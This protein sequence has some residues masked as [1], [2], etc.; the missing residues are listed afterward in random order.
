MR[1]RYYHQV[2]GINSRLDT[3]QAAILRVKLRHLDAAVEARTINANRYTRLLTE[4]GL[5]G[6]DQLGTPYHDADARHVWNQ[7][8]LRVHGGRR[9]ALRAHLAERKVGSEIYYPVPMHKQECFADVP[10]RDNGLEHTETASAEVLNLPIFP[11]LTEA[12]QIQVVESVASFFQ[13]ANRV[14]A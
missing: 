14:A 11:S 9:D 12:E 3:F 13:Q 4:A 10:F 1:P 5:V 6:D 7:Y 8:T 2:V